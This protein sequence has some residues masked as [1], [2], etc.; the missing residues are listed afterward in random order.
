MVHSLIFIGSFIIGTL[1]TLVAVYLGGH[2]VLRTYLE[3]TQTHQE[4][5]DT[6][7]DNTTTN[8]TTEPE[9]YDWSEYE[10]YLTPPI[11]E[12]GEDPEA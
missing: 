9:A 10:S 12:D 7:G 5:P 8:K 6:I 4:V 1:V 2:L 11:G 3:L